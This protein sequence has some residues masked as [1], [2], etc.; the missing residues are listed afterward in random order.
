MS[1]L[2]FS[3][4]GITVPKSPLSPQSPLSSYRLYRRLLIG[5]TSTVPMNLQ[6]GFTVGVRG[7]AWC[8]STLRDLKPQLFN[9]LLCV[10][11]SDQPPKKNPLTHK[12]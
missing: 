4:Q 3:G 1:G 7:G 5:V 9:H 2:G 6:V 10:S 11:T 12:P 8:F